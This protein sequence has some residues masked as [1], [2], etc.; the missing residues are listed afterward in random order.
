[1]ATGDLTPQDEGNGKH[2]GKDG[3]HPRGNTGDPELDAHTE[4]HDSVV[5]PG[6]V[7]GEGEANNKAD[8]KDSDNKDPQGGSESA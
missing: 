3:T 8:G 4:T 2:L 1:M 5:L 7:R 6:G